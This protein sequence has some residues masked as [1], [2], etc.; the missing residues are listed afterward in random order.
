MQ[1]T[2]DHLKEDINQNQH[3]YQRDINH[4]NSFQ[5]ER[6]YILLCVGNS[7]W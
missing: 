7:V 1:S 2:I 6:I 3:W 5:H 4:I